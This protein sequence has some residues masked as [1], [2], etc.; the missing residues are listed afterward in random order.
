[1]LQAEVLWDKDPPVYSNDAGA[2]LL[3][4]TVPVLLESAERRLTNNMGRNE[5]AKIGF[6]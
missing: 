4:A 1:M 2:F 6:S 5:T 3:H